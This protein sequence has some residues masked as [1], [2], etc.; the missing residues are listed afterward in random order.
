MRGVER[1][2]V[3]YWLLIGGKKSAVGGANRE[4]L[5]VLD[6]SNVRKYWAGPPISD[7][8]FVDIQSKIRGESKGGL[9]YCFGLINVTFNSYTTLTFN[10]LTLLSTLLL[11]LTLT[12]LLVWWPQANF[13][14]LYFWVC[15]RRPT[16]LYFTFGSVA[17]G[18]LYFTQLSPILET[19]TLNFKV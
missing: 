3:L 14:L 10:F 13:T 11:T 15:G 7:I 18:R 2:E 19:P 5:A 1:W 9:S 6:L 4:V 17:A 12:L 16:L 8:L